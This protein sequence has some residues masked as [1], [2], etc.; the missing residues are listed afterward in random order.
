MH[1]S[2]AGPLALSYAA[3]IVFASL[4]PFEGWRAQ[5]IDPLVFLLAALPPPY[6]TW[7]DVLTNAA[8]Y[9]PLGFLLALGLLRTG[10]GRRAVLLA[11]LAGALLSLAME[12]LQIYLPRRVP[13][14]LDLALNAAGALAG[15]SIAAL[16]ARLGVLGRWHDWRERWLLPDASGAMVLLALWP[17]ALL[18]PAAVP[19]GLGQVQQRLETALI[20]WLA[21][22][23]SMPSMPL[24]DGLPLR[25]TA[26]APLSP[27][28]ELLC[29]ALGLLA[30]CLLGYCVIRQARHRVLLALALAALGIAL[31]ALSAALSW[32][33]VHA[34]QW[35]NRPARA[36]LWAALA[37]ALLLLALPRRACAAMLLLALVWQLALLNQAPTSAYFA[38]TLQL[39]EQGRFIR[40]YGLGQWLGWLWPY[41]TLLYVLLRVSGRQ[42]HEPLS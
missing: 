18:F 42:R 35:L 4:F 19:F 12:F 17:P 1:Q 37:L 7:F 30:P 10:S 34:W 36:G 31:T 32:G 23:P 40:F 28:G 41:A 8:G 9:A 22:T 2:S 3:L 39:W 38:Q 33:P 5:G 20:G 11:T 21:H 29:V 26:L 27:G 15:A 14:N 6:W 16:L 13:S 24:P 25:Q